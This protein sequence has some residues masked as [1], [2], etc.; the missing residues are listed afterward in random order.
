[1]VKRADAQIPDATAFEV[2]VLADYLN[3]I[4]TFLHFCYDLFP[5]VGWQGHSCTLYFT[6]F[7]LV[8]VPGR[9]YVNPNVH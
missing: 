1:M 5:G 2:D 4:C 8:L 9:V 7:L 6:R 3:D